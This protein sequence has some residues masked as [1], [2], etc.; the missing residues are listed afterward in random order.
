MSAAYWANK[1]KWWGDY[2]GK[3]RIIRKHTRKA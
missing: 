1:V 3:K 2:N